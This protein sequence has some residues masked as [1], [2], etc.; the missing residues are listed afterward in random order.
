MNP[1]DQRVM[2]SSDKMDWQ[3]PAGLFDYV[4]RKVGGFDLDAA[5]HHSNHLCD[6]WLGPAGEWEDALSDRPWCEAGNTIWLNPPYGRNVGA[7][8]ERAYR[9]TVAPNL[10]V[11]CLIFA[12]TDTQ[13]WHDWV[14]KA[15]LVQ[16]IKG[17][18][19]FHRNGQSGQ[20]APAPSCLV[21][22]RYTGE[23]ISPR[24]ESLILP[25]EARR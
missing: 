12:R 10:R 17:R 4:S 21:H 11:V 1:H 3:T 19:A 8:V 25:S 18:I 16:F 9:E 14:M 20:A 15:E 2:F 22:F 6:R 23:P 7:W 13:W 5:A 24:M